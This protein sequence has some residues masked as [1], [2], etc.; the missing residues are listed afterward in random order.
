MNS[1]FNREGCSIQLEQ[2]EEG[3]AA[4]LSTNTQVASWLFFTPVGSIVMIK[5]FEDRE[6]C[7]C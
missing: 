3:A 4:L 2:A 6:Y 5:E 1:P 7:L